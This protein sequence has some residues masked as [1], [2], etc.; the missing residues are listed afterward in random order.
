M[1]DGEAVLREDVPANLEVAWSASGE[2]RADAAR[3]LL[4]AV[5]ADPA[6][7]ARMSQ[8]LA[9]ELGESYAGVTGPITVPLAIVR[10]F[11]LANWRA[12]GVEL[13]E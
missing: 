8:A 11:V 12:R 9:A 1:L 6:E 7:A 5:V 10:A 4:D 13:V 3:M 2:E